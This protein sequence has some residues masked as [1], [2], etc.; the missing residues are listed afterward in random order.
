MYECN[1]IF[2]ENHVACRFKSTHSMKPHVHP[3]MCIIQYDVVIVVLQDRSSHACL[4]TQDMSFKHVLLDLTH[5]TPGKE[6]S[7]LNITT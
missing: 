2:F 7:N 1:C 4:C 6:T 3:F 5:V